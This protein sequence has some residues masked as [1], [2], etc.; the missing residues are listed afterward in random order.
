M[1]VLLYWWFGIFRPQDWI[2]WDVSGLRLPLIAAAVLILPSFLQGKFPRLDNAI[3]RLMVFWLILAVLAHLVNGCEG[4]GAMAASMKNMLVLIL[5]VLLTERIV[6]NH[7]QLLGVVF[8][9]GASLGFYSGKGG[10]HALLGGGAVNYGA[11]NLTGLF[12]GSN[13][14]ALGSAIL[15]FFII[16][17]YQMS[18]KEQYQKYAPAFVQSE[19][20]RL[21]AKYVSMA[22][23][24][25]TVYNVVSLFSRGSAL[26]MAI[27]IL[28]W[29]YLHGKSLKIFIYLGILSVILLAVVPLPQGYEERIRSIFAEEDDMDK[30]AM[31]R[32]HFWRTA[33]EM[34]AEHP[35]GIG[36]GCYAR[37]YDRFDS[38]GGYYKTGRSVHSSH[39]QI[40]AE[41][42]YLGM[43]L[44][45]LLFVVAHKKLMAVR[46]QALANPNHEHS[47]FYLNLAN[48]LACA[49]VVFFI[50]GAFYEQAYNDLI[51]LI[52]G[53][54]I[55]LQRL[56]NQQQEPAKPLGRA[57]EGAR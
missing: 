22:M 12:S 16:F 11:S 38:T 40:L 30:S 28:F 9:V 5:V 25:G 35:I 32:P 7:Q 49:Q 24:F 23:I 52:W 4:G 3:A 50:G 1:G 56:Q 14:F 2:W 46:R 57:V 15:L 42:G 27:G 17:I 18:G 29:I 39:F 36:P 8:I 26:A 44:W 54:T 21:I 31:S 6:S 37:Y 47:F 43:L 53:L 13:G 41:I 10:I 48:A 20:L 19:R 45:L 51:W 55:A 34:T 33:T